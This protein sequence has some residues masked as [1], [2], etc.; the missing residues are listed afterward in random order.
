[1]CSNV[2]KIKSTF[3]F[4]LIPTIVFII[5]NKFFLV[6]YFSKISLL[7]LQNF[8]NSSNLQKCFCFSDLHF[9]S[10]ISGSVITTSV[11]QLLPHQTSENL[12]TSTIQQWVFI[13]YLRRWPHWE[14]SV[15]PNR[16]PNVFRMWYF[17]FLARLVWN[18]Q[19]RIVL[20]VDRYA[21]PKNDPILDPR[22]CYDRKTFSK[23]SVLMDVTDVGHCK[24]LPW[25]LKN[26][27]FFGVPHLPQFVFSWKYKIV[28]K[29]VANGK[30]FFGR[31]G[32]TQGT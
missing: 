27:R 5:C 16:M 14:N 30:R 8:F 18:C 32:L 3:F 19:C 6:R 2:S 26:F 10:R 9:L 17:L 11:D 21:P 12:Q 28:E 24:L 20:P 25:N 13:L 4:F 29:K 15:S 22:L 1:M 23:F 7:F 31:K